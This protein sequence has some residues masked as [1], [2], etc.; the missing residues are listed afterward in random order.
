M[1]SG[2]VQDNESNL[3]LGFRTQCK[4]TAAVSTAVAATEEIELDQ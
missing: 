1:V 3:T 2:P 4:I